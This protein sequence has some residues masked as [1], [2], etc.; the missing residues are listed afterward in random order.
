MFAE[1]E[2]EDGAVSGEH[3]ARF[4][5]AIQR[6]NDPRSSRA[7][8]REGVGAL[9]APRR[10]SSPTTRWSACVRVV[11]AGGPQGRQG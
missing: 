8:G 3:H 5:Q 7:P 4:I 1:V 10:W 6:L 9:G 11:T 2:R